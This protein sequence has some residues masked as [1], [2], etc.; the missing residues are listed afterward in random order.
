MP[1][2]LA[3]AYPSHFSASRT[4]AVETI[5]GPPRT[6]ARPGPDE[7]VHF[8]AKPA[9]GCGCSLAGVEVWKVA[10]T[11]AAALVIARELSALMPRWYAP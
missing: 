5:G 4:V 6:A 7:E 2:S 3:R 8:S 10:V 9:A 1:G 11:V